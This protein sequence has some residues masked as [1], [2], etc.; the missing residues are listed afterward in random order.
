MTA[1]GFT[2]FEKNIG[3]FTEATKDA[4]VFEILGLNLLEY[5]PISKFSRITSN[6]VDLDF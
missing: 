1:G 6:F 4:I 2:E 5:I 3:T